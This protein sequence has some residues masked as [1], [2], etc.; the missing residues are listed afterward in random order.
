LAIA[1]AVDDIEAAH[2]AEGNVVRFQPK[3]GDNVR[4]ARVKKAKAPTAAEAVSAA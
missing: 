2:A 4:K 3:G 1:A